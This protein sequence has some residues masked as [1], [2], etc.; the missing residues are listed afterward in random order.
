[1]N[2]KHKMSDNIIKI[3]LTESDVEPKK[4]KRIMFEEDGIVFSMDEDSDYEL[5]EDFIVVWTPTVT[6]KR[7]SLK[8]SESLLPVYKDLSKTYNIPV[9]MIH[10]RL[11]T[12]ILNK[13]ELLKNINMKV[14]D[15]IEAYSVKKNTENFN[16]F[17]ANKVE[18]KCLFDNLKKPLVFYLY[19]SQNINDLLHLCA[20]HIHCSSDGLELKYDGDKIK[21]ED[22]PI[23]LEFEGGECLEVHT[24]KS[25]I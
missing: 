6:E 24:K 19:P 4:K 5:E 20:K 7:F 12:K 17:D 9:E 8:P 14:T 3:D 22:T 2:I 18:V 13:N 10:L 11:K 23:S 21:P 25:K 16:D 1:M 15:V